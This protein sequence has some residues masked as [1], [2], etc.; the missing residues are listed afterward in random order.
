[1][2][3]SESCARRHT[4]PVPDKLLVQ[5]PEDGADQLADD[6]GD[7]M[8]TAIGTGAAM[9]PI[10]SEVDAPARRWGGDPA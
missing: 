2:I 5:V 6:L 1:M 4:W 9:V 10:V 3:L 8:T 7:C